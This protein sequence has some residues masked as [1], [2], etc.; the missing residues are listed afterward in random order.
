MDSRS[1]AGIIFSDIFSEGKAYLCLLFIF[2]FHFL[3]KTTSVTWLTLWVILSWSHTDRSLGCWTQ[4]LQTTK[5]FCGSLLRDWVTLQ[6]L[7]VRKLIKRDSKMNSHVPGFLAFAIVT[8][9]YCK[10]AVCLP[11]PLAFL[12]GLMTASFSIAKAWNLAG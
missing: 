2:P 4:C 1:K 7:M 10:P 9:I 11:S 8:A 12:S 5:T 3:K 6:P